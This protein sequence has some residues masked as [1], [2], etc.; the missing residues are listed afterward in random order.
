MKQAPSN[1]NFKV[2]YQAI[3]R[4]APRHP[5]TTD[6]QEVQPL[7]KRVRLKR[8]KWGKLTLARVL[9]GGRLSDAGR[10]VRYV[11]IV[12]AGL[13]LAWGPAVAY[14]KFGKVAYT[15]HFSLIL[16]GSGA[17]SSIS[18]SE[19]GQ[20]TSASTPAF[21][22]SSISP[23][24]T[25]KN[26]L[27]S[28][29]VVYG[30][31]AALKIAPEN[32]SAPTIKL[33]DETSFITVEIEGSSSEDA[34]NRAKAIQDRFFAE[35]TML[36]EDEIKRRD[37]S[38]IDT[39][40]KYETVVNDIQSKISAL[41]FSSGLSSTDQFNSLI[42][43]ADTL[44]VAIAEMEAQHAKVLK[45]KKGLAANLKLDDGLASTTMKLHA[46]PEF[47][48]LA[49]ATAK[50]EAIYASAAKQFG[51][52]H[53]K[54]TDARAQLLGARSHMM[55]RAS[56]ITGIS[57]K[58]L[59][60]KIDLSPTGQRGTLLAQLVN[61][62]TDEQGLRGQI[63]SMQDDL[64]ARRKRIASL[65]HVHLEL[66]RLTSG[67]KV[68]EAVFISALARISTSK[69]DIFASYPMVQV[70]EA[71]IMPLQPSSPNKKI[72][73][74]A[75]AGSTFLLIFGLI[76]AWVRRPLID[77]LLTMARKPNEEPLSS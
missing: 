65:V 71:P 22:A 23:T 34:R 20:A 38:T 47:S 17:N 37:D 53:P 60:G 67:L 10:V 56:L 51:A 11:L 12:V 32:F 50:A 48:A 49:D 57:A 66:D 73:I 45:S 35:L 8:T 52:K 58:N 70:T 42:T 44:Q 41:K 3:E 14:M 7:L 24:V 29:N 43:S 76:L 19:I 63:L 6:K 59:V 55:S 9:K 77:K 16:P 61:L 72:A 62:A 5:R 18:V 54:V 27:M 15:S 2:L 21:S 13:S 4:F 40:K 75:A 46:D 1:A 74:G 30:A 33:V 64:I 68:A 26:L 31:A 69:T 36:R 39:V 28:A 25:Y